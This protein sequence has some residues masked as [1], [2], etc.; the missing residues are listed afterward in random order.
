MTVKQTSGVNAIYFDVSGLGMTQQ[1]QWMPPGSAMNATLN[2]GTIPAN[3]GQFNLTYNT[4]LSPG[5]ATLM[6]TLDR[7]YSLGEELSVQVFYTTRQAPG[8]VDYAHQA[9]SWVYADQTPSGTQPA[10]YSYCEPN[11][12]RSLIPMQDT[13]AVRLTYAACVQAPQAATVYMSA[14]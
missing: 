12:C 5:S 13:P 9:L 10:M 3:V 14:T 4:S 1:V 2:E 6:I 7:L 11:A 8:S